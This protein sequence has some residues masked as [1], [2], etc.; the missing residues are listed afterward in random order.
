MF[1]MSRIREAGC[2][3]KDGWEGRLCDVEK[4]DDSSRLVSL[5]VLAIVSIVCICTNFYRRCVLGIKDRSTGMESGDLSTSGSG[6]D[7]SKSYV[8]KER[9]KPQATVNSF[10]GRPLSM[11]QI[12]VAP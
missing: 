10:N 2:R 3:C 11:P 1:S 12:T 4:D 5:T 7:K 6:Y 8:P 9:V